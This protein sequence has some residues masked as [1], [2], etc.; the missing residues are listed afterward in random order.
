MV[1]T[2]IETADIA[3]M[4]DDLNKVTKQF[5]SV[6]TRCNHSNQHHFHRGFMLSPNVASQSVILIRTSVAGKAGSYRRHQ[7]YP[8]SFEDWAS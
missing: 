8:I 4:K 2:A 5:S 6:G 1:A 3:L 7:K